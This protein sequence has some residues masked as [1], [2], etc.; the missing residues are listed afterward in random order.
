[1]K[2]DV[3]VLENAFT[4]FLSLFKITSINGLLEGVA[5]KTPPCW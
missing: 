5:T 1:M 3:Y 4:D 2:K